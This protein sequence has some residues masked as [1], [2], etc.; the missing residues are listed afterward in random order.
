MESVELNYMKNAVQ[1]AINKSVLKDMKSYFEDYGDRL[2]AAIEHKVLYQ[3]SG[4]PQTVTATAQARYDKKLKPRWIPKFLWNRIKTEPVVVTEQRSARYQP[5]WIYPENTIDL[6]NKLGAPVRM[7]L[8][9]P[10]DLN[11]YLVEDN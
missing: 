3:D 8:Q 7:L 6:Q 5:R 2:V 10:V 4:A 1:V 11:S 9:Q